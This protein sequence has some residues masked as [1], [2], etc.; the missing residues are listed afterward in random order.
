M[1]RVR[2]LGIRFVLVGVLHGV[3]ALASPEARAEASDVSALRAEAVRTLAASQ[4][5]DAAVTAAEEA[6]REARRAWDV[7]AAEALRVTRAARAEAKGKGQ[8]LPVLGPPRDPATFWAALKQ[9]EEEAR[10]VEV[11]TRAE[12]IAAARLK[13]SPPEEPCRQRPVTIIVDP[14]ADEFAPRTAKP[15]LTEIIFQP[16]PGESAARRAARKSAKR[17]AAALVAAG[18][19]VERRRTEAQRAR[20]AARKAV[21]A[22]DWADVEALAR[23]APPGEAVH[24]IEAYQTSHPGAPRDAPRARLR[25]LGAL[26][27]L[28]PLAAVFAPEADGTA[29]ATPSPAPSATDRASADDPA[30]PDHL[31]ALAREAQAWTAVAFARTGPAREPAMRHA[32]ALASRYDDARPLHPAAADVLDARIRLE[33][34]LGNGR[35]AITL[36]AVLVREFPQSANARARLY[37]ALSA[38]L[39]TGDDAT[40]A[41]MAQMALSRRL[42]ETPLDRARALLV[43]G[44][45]RWSVHGRSDSV[46]Q[47]FEAALRALGP[48]DARRGR[49]S[50]RAEAVEAL[51][52]AGLARLDALR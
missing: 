24:A 1:H 48:A 18:A 35:R 51:A 5:A 40:A 14:F 10:E 44:Y 50:A 31:D 26:P 19:T 43:L 13:G 15:D 41:E 9:A 37:A 8:R 22:A 16:V 4:A 30:A 17:A 39:A 25:E 27:D 36:T 21:D 38:L 42:V 12:Q 34:A 29:A 45:T 6:L 2:D 23:S 3:G 32:L 28:R 33:S 20:F 7:A 46:R 49:E 52:R 47:D 11:R